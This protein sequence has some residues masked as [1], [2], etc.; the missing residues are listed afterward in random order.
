MV[1]QFSQE[2]YYLTLVSAVRRKTAASVCVGN[3]RSRKTV[4]V[5]GDIVLWNIVNDNRCL[6]FI[7][8]EGSVGALAIPTYNL[9]PI[10]QSSERTVDELNLES[11][12]TNTFGKTERGAINNRWKQRQ[13]QLQEDAKLSALQI[14]SR[15]ERLFFSVGQEDCTLRCWDEYDQTESYQFKSKGAGRDGGSTSGGGPVTTML[16]LWSLNRIAT[17]HENGLVCLWNSDTGTKVV[18]RAL[19]Q[20]VSSFIEASNSHSRLLVGADY[21]GMVAVWNLTLHALNP[22]CLQTEGAPFAGFHDPEDPGIL[23]LA[24][25]VR[26]KTLFSGGNDCCIKIWRGSSTDAATGTERFHHESVCTLKCTESFVLSG[27]EGGFLCLSKIFVDS[28]MG[29]NN[30]NKTSLNNGPLLPIISRLVLF[31]SW[32]SLVPSRCLAD[33]CECSHLTDAGGCI[34]YAVHI[35]SGGGRTKIWE[36]CAQP[37]K[38]QQQAG[39]FG[40]HRGKNRAAFSLEETVLSTT[41]FTSAHQLDP[42]TSGV[43][44]NGSAMGLSTFDAAS[45][46]VYDLHHPDHYIAVSELCSVLHE[47]HEISCC[48]LSYNSCN[49]AALAA[50]CGNISL[51]FKKSC[52][53]YFGTVGGTILR[54]SF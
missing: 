40:A 27:D 30:C 18:S 28:E 31:C 35:G 54:Y 19:R 45:L 21:G 51:S 6:E 2:G 15:E 14:V 1:S 42:A 3:T 37:R 24:Y 5:L 29:G 23:S 20:T 12:Y 32:M 9:L 13:L 17:G 10:G 22:T 47:K 7:G 48:N 38:A 4:G 25:H 8:H 26:S 46:R 41:H 39:H 49:A 16:V 52:Y 50:E 34:A 11:K 36:I 44:G 53:L 43:T 33:L